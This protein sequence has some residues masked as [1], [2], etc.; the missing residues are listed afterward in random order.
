[1]GEYEAQLAMEK[2]VF[3]VGLLRFH[4]VYGPLSDY[5]N[6]SSQAIPSLIRKAISYPT[7][8][9]IVWGSGNQYRDFVYISDVVRALLAVKDHGMNCGVIQIGSRQPTTISELAF[10]IARIVGEQKNRSI[11]LEFDFCKPEGDQG[12]IAGGDR[13]QTLLN[14][15]AKVSLEDGLRMTVAW[16]E[17]VLEY[18]NERR[19]PLS[20]RSRA[21]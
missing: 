10:R 17:N 2:D 5:S 1:M 9:Y 20:L 16:M 4:N 21:G 14:W 11:E 12:R 18:I 15:D 8:R 7:E 6:T 13:A 19:I 3:N